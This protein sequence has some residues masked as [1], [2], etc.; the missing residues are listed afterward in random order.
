MLGLALL[1]REAL[2]VAVRAAILGVLRKPVLNRV[3]RLPHDLGG[4]PGPQT[5]RLAAGLG[6]GFG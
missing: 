2:L 5:V 3:H 4:R 1:I 6:L